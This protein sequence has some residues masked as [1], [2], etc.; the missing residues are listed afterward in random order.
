MGS[1]VVRYAPMNRAHILG[2]PN[3]IPSI[4]CQTYL[5]RFKAHEH[6]HKLGVELH[7]SSLMKMFMVNLEGNAR[8]WYEGL[9]A[10][11]LYSLRDFHTVFHEHF[12]YQYPSLLLIQYCCTHD[13]GFFENLK[14]I[15]G[16][17]QYMVEEILE[18]LNEYSFQ[19]ERQTN[20]H[21]IQEN[22]QQLVMSSLTEIDKSQNSDSSSYIF[23]L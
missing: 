1:I 21:D 4:D 18:I 6:I 2:F 10:E 17:D 8:S 16:D 22:S 3:R 23:F 14:Y 7:E 9:L 13:K 20:C 12:K 5:T 19:K 11:S 15:Y